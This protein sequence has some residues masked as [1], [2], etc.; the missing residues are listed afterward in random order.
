MI[1]AGQRDYIEDHAYVPEHI[2]QYVT[3]ISQTEPFLFEDFLVYLKRDHLIFVGYPFLEPFEEKR[4][5]AALEKAIRRFRPETVSLTAP[6]LPVFPD[7]HSHP[8]T[9]HYYR[10]DL[11]ALSISQKL[12]NMLSRAGRELSVEKNRKFDEE[13]RKMVDAF[14]KT[15]PVDPGTQFIF[16]RIGEYLSSSHSAWICDA[17]NKR[18]DLVAFDVAEFGAKDYAFYMFNFSSEA[19]YLPGASDLIL[20]KVIGRAKAENKKYINLGL[21]INPGVTFFKRKWGGVPFLPYSFCL[22][23]PQRADILGTLLQKL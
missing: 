11:S 23:K 2:S 13:H 19:L 5:K 1:T 16:K 3:A 12:R 6:T 18:G 8:P 15:H 7:G 20:S 21:G 22:Y 9:D 17:R 4:M 14:L 10:L